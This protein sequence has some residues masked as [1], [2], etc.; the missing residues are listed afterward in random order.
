MHDLV[1]AEAWQHAAGHCHIGLF[2][3]VDA[4]RLI[5]PVHAVHAD[6]ARQGID[7]SG[8]LSSNPRADWYELSSGCAQGLMQAP[9]QHTILGETTVA[10]LLQHW[11][12]MYQLPS[13]TPLA[14]LQIPSPLHKLIPR[15]LWSSIAVPLI[16]RTKLYSLMDFKPIPAD[17]D[18]LSSAA[19]FPGTSAMQDLSP[20]QFREAHRPPLGHFK[21]RK[22]PQALL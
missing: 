19:A 1:A 8:L 10:M 20:Q 9:L 17:D 22:H 3:V 15:G 6:A 21:A 12:T 2:E 5:D 11:S 4:G 7:T 13:T 16:A 18:S 14:T